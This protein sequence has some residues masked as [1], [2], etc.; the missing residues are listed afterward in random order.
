MKSKSEIQTSDVISKTCLRSLLLD[1][2]LSPH[3]L[4]AKIW[5]TATGKDGEDI[6]NECRETAALFVGCLIE[7]RMN[8]IGR[9]LEFI[10]SLNGVAECEYSARAEKLL[11]EQGD[12]LRLRGELKVETLAEN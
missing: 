3:R 10:E 11:D 1:S 5:N 7:G 8:E 6:C 2:G 9:E 4:S 12:L